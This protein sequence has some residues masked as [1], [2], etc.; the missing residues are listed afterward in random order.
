MLKQSDFKM[1]IIKDLGTSVN[2]K[3]NKKGRYCI[4]ECTSCSS[5]VT[6]QAAR[7]KR[8]N[9]SICERCSKIKNPPNRNHHLYPT[10]KGERQRCQNPTNENFKH[11]GGRG[12]LFSP[13]FD[14]FK[15][16]LN[17][18]T[19]LEDYK[20]PSYTLDRIDNNKGYFPGNLRWASQSTQTI[21]QR[22]RPSK[23]GHRNITKG[24]NYQVRITRKGIKHYLGTFKTLEEAT[25]RRDLFLT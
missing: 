19:S 20:K 18:V 1:K 14:N 4:F 13:E 24:K 25:T 23:S 16:W 2:S 9:I 6:L 17:H 21:N 10:W 5:H 3:G 11:Y 22:K 8:E 7:V 15:T 12:I